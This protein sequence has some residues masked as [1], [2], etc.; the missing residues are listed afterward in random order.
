MVINVEPPAHPC[1]FDCALFQ[2]CN[3]QPDFVCGS[4]VEPAT[5]EEALGAGVG[6]PSSSDDCGFTSGGRFIDGTQPDLDSALNC[7]LAVGTGTGSGTELT[8]QAMVEAVDGPALTQDCNDGFL[9]DDAL[10]V[11][12]FVTDEDDDAADSSGNPASWKV[13]LVNA[14]G[15]AEQD[16]FALGLYG[17]NEFATPTCLEEAEYS[18]R[19]SSFMGLWGP[20]GQTGSVCAPDYAPFF[21]ELLG[22]VSAACP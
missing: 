21:E 9:R 8:M 4:V 10:L 5:C 7:A 6:A 13:Q 11:M 19:L 12:V 1:D 3:A 2:T 22:S 16:I 20:R 15:G 17:D 14:K 18:V